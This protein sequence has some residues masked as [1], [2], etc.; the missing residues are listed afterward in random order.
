MQNFLKN[1]FHFLSLSGTML[2]W[3][4][5]VPA[6]PMLPQW[7]QLHHNSPDLCVLFTSWRECCLCD[8]NTRHGRAAEEGQVTS[9]LTYLVEQM[10]QK[11]VN[12]ILKA[13][14]LCGNL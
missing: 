3:K 9:L 8:V 10:S 5:P 7:K 4:C 1:L 11:I 14:G 6:V 12:D 13:W 2:M